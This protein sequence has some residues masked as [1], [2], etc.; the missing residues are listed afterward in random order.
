MAFPFDAVLVLGKGLRR[1]RERGLR[2]LRARSAAASAAVRAGAGRALSLEAKLE[3]QDREGSAIV[4]EN[5]A[6]LGVPAEKTVL[7]QR[8]RSTRDEAVLARD[9]ARELGIQRLLVVTSAYHVPRSRQLFEEVLGPRAV[10][11][12]GTAALLALAND[13]ERRW[14]LAGEPTIATMA[15]EARIERLLLTAEAALAPLPRPLR[16]K[17]ESF[18]GTLWRG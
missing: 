15:A 8:S 14:I 10:S 11:V 5:L 9:L 12:H 3:G 1:D 18:A 4:A 2:E 7:R 13:A 16:W 17:I 6:T